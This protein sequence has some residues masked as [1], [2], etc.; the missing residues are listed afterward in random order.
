MEAQGYPAILIFVVLGIGIPLAIVRPYYAFLFALLVVTAGNTARFNQ[1]R[2]PGLGPLLNLTD[3]CLLVAFAAFFFDRIVRNKPVW[4]PRIAG[5]L[6][7]VLAIAAIQSF[8]K[9]GWTY[10]TLRAFRWALD[11]PIGLLL[12]A[13]LVT[14]AKRARLLIVSLLLGTILSAGQHLLFAASLWR[15]MSLNMENYGVIRTISYG[16]MSATFLLAAVVWRPAA[17]PAKKVLYLL[18]GI[19]FVTSQLLNQTRSL[20]LAMAAT[21]ACL[22]VLFKVRYSLRQVLRLCLLLCVVS[23]AFVYGLRCVMPGLD[24]VRLVNERMETLTVDNPRFSE[25]TGTRKRDF[26]VEMSHWWEGTLIFGR[27]LDFFQTIPNPRDPR[28][29]VAFGHLGYV[30]YLSQTGLIGLMVYGFCFPLSVLYAGRLLWR[31]GREASVRYLALFGTALIVGAAITFTMSSSFLS[32]GMAAVGIVCGSMWSL[33]HR[34]TRAANTRGLEVQAV[35][36]CGMGG[37]HCETTH[38]WA[39]Q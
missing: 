17:T 25:H 32:M 6:V 31:Y 26:Q 30:T 21:A 11:L 14:S 22:M 23:T 8:W 5:L 3:A 7:F 1:T 39:S 2:L 37:P 36:T 24:A 33:A 12:G 4:V 13:N 34:M 38:D 35:S 16:G 10:E 29:Y 18:I 28:R 9:L 27:G 15:T 19:L 20:W